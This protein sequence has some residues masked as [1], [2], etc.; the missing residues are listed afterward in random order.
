MESLYLFSIY[1]PPPKRRHLVSS[2]QIAIHILYSSKFLSPAPTPLNSRL[3][4]P[5]ANVT[6]PTGSS[7]DL[8]KT[9]IPTLKINIKTILI[10]SCLSLVFLQFS[11]PQYMVTSF[12]TA[13]VKNLHIILNFSLSL[14]L[15]I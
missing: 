1:I 4:G 9:N 15:H 6:S 12:F 11:P 7:L 10:S 13:Q 3:R 14:I 2:L 5:S 8:L